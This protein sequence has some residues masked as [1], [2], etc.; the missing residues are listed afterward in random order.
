MP[1]LTLYSNAELIQMNA[2]A[3]DESKRRQQASRL[4]AITPKQALRE[5]GQ[6]LKDVLYD[7]NGNTRRPTLHQLLFSGNRARGVG[8]ILAT[9]AALML[10]VNLVLDSRD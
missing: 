2:D 10:F 8:L 7:L 4:S 1:G 5:A 9:L 3:R 6:T